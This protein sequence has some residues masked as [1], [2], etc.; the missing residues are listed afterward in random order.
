MLDKLTVALG[1][2]NKVTEPRLEKIESALRPIFLALPKNEHGNLEHTGVRYA[3][4]RLFVLRHGM[5][6]KG[7]E[8]GSQGWNG[9]SSPT[10]VLDDRVPAYVQSLFEER[11]RGRGL[12]MHEV[13]ILAATLEHL[14][15][16]EAQERLKAAYDVHAVSV[17]THLTAKEVETIVDTYM[18]MFLMGKSVA[19]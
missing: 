4:H 12:G 16:E 8:P 6:V 15:H 7:L 2:G 19:N 13:A 3:L 1:S 14:I 10:E 9:T 11:L 5:Y 17:E 18:V